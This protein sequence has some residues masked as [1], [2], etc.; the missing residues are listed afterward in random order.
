MKMFAVLGIYLYILMLDEFV[1]CRVHAY[2]KS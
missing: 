2:G 1:L